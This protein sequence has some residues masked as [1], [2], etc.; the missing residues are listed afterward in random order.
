[1]QALEEKEDEERFS[2]RACDGLCRWSS[3][4]RMHSSLTPVVDVGRASS[5]RR[6]GLRRPW[7]SARGP[8]AE[9]E[10]LNEALSSKL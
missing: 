8:L 9:H 2:E 1:M 3:G 10:R 6:Q 7:G 5:A 4:N